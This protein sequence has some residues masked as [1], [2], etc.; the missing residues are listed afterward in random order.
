MLL[1][2]SKGSNGLEAIQ[3][4]GGQVANDNM[5]RKYGGVLRGSEILQ[6]NETLMYNA[7]GVVLAAVAPIRRWHILL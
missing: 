3:L 2:I 6:N 4:Q 1:K 5:L 7:F